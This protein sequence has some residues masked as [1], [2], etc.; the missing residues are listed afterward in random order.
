M[1]IRKAL[2][3]AC[4]CTISLFL[5]AW[6]TKPVKL[7]NDTKLIN[8]D[9][10]I[11][12]V[13]P[14]AEEYHAPSEPSVTESDVPSEETK[15]TEPLNITI[16]I[17]VQGMSV[18]FDGKEIEETADLSNLI[19]NNLN[20]HTTFRLID[21]FADANKYKEIYRLMHDLHNEIGV[22]FVEAQ[23]GTA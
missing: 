8:L 10:A 3:L 23:G 18:I 21:N 5:I 2:S 19:R 1:K 9:N 17:V 13:K 20:S 7:L 12:Y 22:I 15:E 11:G 4:I 16:D 14:G 6:G